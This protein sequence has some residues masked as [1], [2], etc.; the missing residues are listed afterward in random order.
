MGALLSKSRMNDWGS[1]EMQDRNRNTTFMSVVFLRQQ[2]Q[3][4]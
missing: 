1:M 4:Y 2:I 3:I